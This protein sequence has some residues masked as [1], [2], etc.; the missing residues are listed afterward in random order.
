MELSGK[1]DEQVLDRADEQ[2]ISVVSHDH[3]RPHL[4]LDS[5]NHA[6]PENIGSPRNLSFEF[7]YEE[8]KD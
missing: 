4:E 8:S 6:L 1:D 2:K 7:D 5:Q 3:Q